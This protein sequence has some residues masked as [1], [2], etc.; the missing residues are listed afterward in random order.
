MSRRLWEE[1]DEPFHREHT[2][3]LA[4]IGAPAEQDGDGS[5]PKFTE[6]TARALLIPHVFLHEVGHRLDRMTTRSRRR[7]ARGEASAERYAIGYV[8]GIKDACID[9]FGVA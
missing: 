8:D 5:S 4:R 9:R 2:D 7:S 6:T 3:V 1:S